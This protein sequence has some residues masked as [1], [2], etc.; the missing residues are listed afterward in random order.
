MNQKALSRPAGGNVIA[1]DPERLIASAI[2][3]QVSVEAL[4][5]LLAMRQQLRAERS[6]DAF[7]AA[8]ANFQQTCP[9]IPKRRTAVVQTKS[10]GS[11]TYSFA[12]LADILQAIGPALA[13]Q[14]LSVSF[15]AQQT[16][17]ALQV[18]C[19]VSHCDGHSEATTIPIPIGASGRL[20][21]SQEIGT[22]LTYGRRYA[23]SA[24]LGIVT[25]DEEA[26]TWPEARPPKQRA[27]SPPRS[28]D[29]C[30][31]LRE[32]VLAK[33]A[34]LDLVDHAARLGDWLQ[35]S[36]GTPA[37]E[38]L[39]ADQLQHTLTVLPRFAAQIAK[40]EGMGGAQ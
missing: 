15:D 3:H 34:E 23:L 39:S 28:A 25:S 24:A 1:L 14:G 9:P 4:E 5:R 29:P 26:N 35:R 38:G 17:Q 22:A 6:R 13:A 19:R 20:P 40:E 36:F 37:L 16:G 32:Q 2:E 21:A 10:G 27:K 12:N 8:M 31:E 7:A 18:S 30:P 33:I 11:Y